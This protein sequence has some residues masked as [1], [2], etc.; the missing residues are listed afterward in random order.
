[1][2]ANCQP[3][4]FVVDDDQAVCEALRFFLHLSGFRVETYHRAEDFLDAYDHRRLGCLLLD[5]GMPGM[6]GLELQHELNARH[7]RLPVIFMSGH[8]DAKTRD[9][10]LKR[11]AIGFIEKP[12]LSQVLLEHVQ[13]ALKENT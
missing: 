1:M 10:V 6:S 11:G 3:T 7:C 5:M 9:R 12:F 2:N 8:G 4:V 13:S